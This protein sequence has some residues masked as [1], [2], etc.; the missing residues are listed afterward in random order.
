[1]VIRSFT[2]G[3][4]R[5]GVTLCQSHLSRRDRSKGGLAKPTS[6]YVQLL[7]VGIFTCVRLFVV[8]HSAI[9]EQPWHV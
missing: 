6:S 8:A 9:L 1:M 4:R 7:A 5:D 3:Y 2:G